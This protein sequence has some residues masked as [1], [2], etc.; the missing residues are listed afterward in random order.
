M[1]ECKLGMNLQKVESLA[2]LYMLIYPLVLNVNFLWT[3]HDTQITRCTKNVEKQGCFMVCKN[4]FQ[5]LEQ[6][7][8]TPYM[9]LLVSV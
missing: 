1:L 3:F 7:I 8:L 2:L 9:E 5:D 6:I 4:T